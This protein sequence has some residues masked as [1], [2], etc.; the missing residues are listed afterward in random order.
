[1]LEGLMPQALRIEHIG[2]PA[3]G[4]LFDQTVTFYEMIFG[5]K[6]IREVNGKQHV[7]FL[8]DGQGGV[9]EVLDVEGQPSGPPGH[10]AF[11]VTLAE[12][13]ETRNRLAELGVAFD[14]THE[15]D[16]GDLLAYF[17]DP[18]GNGPQI[19]GRKTALEYRVLS[20]D[21]RAIRLDARKLI[22]S[23]TQS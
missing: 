6:R 1:M 7:T 23:P 3:E 13:E 15:T 22:H 11:S 20:H 21:R 18:A 2:I 4:A 12:F 10:L 16:T 5:L 14:P 8:S 17:K 9:I 19:I